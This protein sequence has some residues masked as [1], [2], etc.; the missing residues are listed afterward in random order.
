MTTAWIPLRSRA[1]E[2]RAWT[3]I[4]AKDEPLVRRQAW[5][6]GASGYAQ[7]YARTPDGRRTTVKLHRLI[8]GLPAGTLAQ[9]DHI[10][11]DRLDNRRRNLRRVNG[12]AEQ[13]QNRAPNR[14]SSSRFRGVTWSKEKRKWLASVRL[15]GRLHYLGA[16]RD[17]AAAAQAAHEFRQRHMPLYI[18]G[19]AVLKAENLSRS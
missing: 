3:L 16:Y 8:L 11:G 1:G 7:G 2:I 5:N 9:V 15:G 14:G 17:E 18:G 13:M 4:D 6:V 12:A 10:N 19:R